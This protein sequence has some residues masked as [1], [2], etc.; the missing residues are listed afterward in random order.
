MTDTAMKSPWQ[1]VDVKAF[2]EA[3]L[4]EL[5]SKKTVITPG[6]R[7]GDD[8]THGSR[9]N[10]TNWVERTRRGKLPEYI[11]IVRN[12]LMKDGHP[13]S[14]ATALAVAAIK[15]W[16]RG[17][18]G[19]SAK[20]KA[21]AAKALAEW[22][23]MKAEKSDSTAL[24]GITPFGIEEWENAQDQSETKS[25][26]EVMQM[27]HK[28]VGVAG[29]KSLDQE[30][31]G[32]VEAFVSVTGLKDN[33]ADIIEP[34][35]YKDTLNARLPKG[36]WS[37]QWDKPIS[38][39]L[40]I[41]EVLPGSPELP[42]TLP[43]GDPWP[44]TAGA[45]KVKMQ[46]NLKTQRGRDAY[47]DV[48]FFGDQQEW[49]IGYNVPKGKA[50]MDTKMQAR[51]IKGLDLY[52]FSPVLF[53]AMPVARTA[54]VKEAQVA[55]KALQGVDIDE[56]LTEVKSLQESHSEFMEQKG[57]STD[58]DEFDF[59]EEEKELDFGSLATEGLLSAENIVILQKAHTVLTELLDAAMEV[60]E[61]KEALGGDPEVKVFKIEDI[62]SKTFA[63]IVTSVKAAGVLDSDQIEELTDMAEEFDTAVNE[64]NVDDVEGSAEVLLDTIEEFMDEA[65]PHAEGA[66]KALSGAIASILTK[67][68]GDEEE[69]PEEGLGEPSGAT[70]ENASEGGSEDES[71]EKTIDLSEFDVSG[72]KS[73]LDSIH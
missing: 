14:R 8:A 30:G 31:E 35:A 43:N 17:G 7:V 4:A 21:A 37:H 45:L 36:I 52:E 50:Q 49:S 3:C 39:T 28:T 66:L 32:I 34:G 51:R 5:E 12:G 61:L 64:K 69:S 38:K 46:F 20:V 11:R 13:E 2:S 16:A 55:Y 6:G 59:E 63:D 27:E 9:A 70:D 71:G 25:A 53:G 18:G 62:E 65:D 72:M 24:E 22:E 67:N 60:P 47:E 19:V 33:V 68:F 58:D 10:G 56:W 54:S 73:L 1:G 29:L 41:K 42:E 40:D 15:R 57:F 26:G 44:A 23:A 48:L